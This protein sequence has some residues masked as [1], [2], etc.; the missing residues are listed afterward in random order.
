MIGFLGARCAPAGTLGGSSARCTFA[1]GAPLCIRPSTASVFPVGPAAGLLDR[2]AGCAARQAIE[3]RP[4]ASGATPGFSPFGVFPLFRRLPLVAARLAGGSAVR[5]RA[6]SAADAQASLEPRL[7]AAPALGPAGTSLDL[8]VRAAIGQP[9]RLAGGVASAVGG[10]AFLQTGLAGLPPRHRRM[11]AAPGAASPGGAL[12]RLAPGAPAFVFPFPLGISPRLA[13]GAQPGV[14]GAGRAVALFGASLAD[15]PPWRRRAV[16]AARTKTGGLPPFDTPAK[17]LAALRLADF[18]VPV[19]HG[20]L[21]RG[22]GD[23]L[24]H[25]ACGR[26]GAPRPRFPMP[27]CRRGC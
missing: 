27:A 20:F 15:R 10:A 22:Y 3:R 1:P 23:R 6:L 7:L 24:S 12:R 8:R 21:L 17:T 25:V 18:R 5:W 11:L 9:G 13:G 26:R 16:S 14:A 19:C 2:V 4:A